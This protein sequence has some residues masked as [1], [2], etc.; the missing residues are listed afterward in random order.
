MRISGGQLKGRRIASR[1]LFSK[2]SEGDELRPT[3]SKVRE[4]IFDILQNDIKDADFLD[5]Y[6][7]T[8]TVG[9]EA[10]SRG[11]GRVFLIENNYIRS[12]EIMKY[13]KEIKASDRVK[14]YREK[15][16]YFLKRA[17]VAGMR[18]DII[19]ADPPYASD[20]IMKV[21]HFIDEN[22]TLKED[23]CLI[24]EHSFRSN[25]PEHTKYLKF[26]K[27]YKYGDTMLTLYRKRI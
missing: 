21:L 6:A 22:D 5:L 12:D 2:R 1:R 13:V 25:L 14:V 9:L 18:F 23:G 19:F 27:N 8:G 20:E 3:S 4:A 10:L 11:A 7:G 15:V 17:S 24:V 26:I 16:E